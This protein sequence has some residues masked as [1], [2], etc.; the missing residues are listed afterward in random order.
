MRRLLSILSL[1]ALTACSNSPE[2]ET[3]EITALKLIKDTL[4]APTG[5]G[6]YINARKLVSRQMIDAAIKAV[7]EKT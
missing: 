6:V 5:D 3:G 1:L 2:L 4:E 7:E